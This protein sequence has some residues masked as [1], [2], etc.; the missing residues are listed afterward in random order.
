MEE[1]LGTIKTFGFNFAPRGWSLCDGQLLAIASNTAL[2]S[3]L[4]TTYGGDG[5]T[6]FGLPDLRGR[7]IVHPGTGPGFSTIRWGQV[8]GSESNQ[9]TI[10]EMPSHSHGLVQGQANITTVTQVKAA[11]GTTINE[12]DNG[13]YPFAS[14]G[15]APNMYSE[16]TTYTDKVGGVVSES[17]ITGSTSATGGSQPFPIRSPFLGVYMCIAIVGVYPS[18][19]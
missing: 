19:S 10:A 4:G 12:P 18:R 8:G 14:G 16:D 3:L 9:I 1:Y 13:T 6:T 17:T 11:N 5:R 2:F 15:G 7:S